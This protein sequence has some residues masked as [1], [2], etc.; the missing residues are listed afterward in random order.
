[1]R[2]RARVDRL[3]GT[4][5]CASRP[6]A[7]GRTAIGEFAETAISGAGE[8]LRDVVDARELVGRDLQVHLEAR[9]ARLDHHRVVL[10][11]SSS[12]RPLIE[13]SNLP[14]RSAVTI[15]L[16]VHVARARHHVVE[17]EVA[18]CASSAGCP[19]ARRCMPS[20]RG[21]AARACSTSSSSCVSICDEA[22]AGEQLRIAVD[23]ELELAELGRVVRVARRRS[24]TCSDAARRAPALV[25]RGTSPARRRC[26]ARR[27]RTC[28]SA[29][30]RSSARRSAR[31]ARHE[32][33]LR[34]RRRARPS[35]SLCVR[36]VGHA[37]LAVVHSPRILRQ[38]LAPRQP[39]VVPLGPHESTRFGMPCRP[40]TF[41]IA[42]DSPMSS[43]LALAR[44][45]A[46]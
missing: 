19:S 16:S 1:M 33:A 42:H 18:S 40:S 38:H 26:G 5:R 30:M 23:L 2:W 28:S 29:S 46:G 37:S 43:A 39:V 17:A 24:S 45:R 32:L 4:A 25:D 13:T 3:L 41:A 44:R 8:H 20:S 27:S 10:E 12:S 36:V 14:P 6:T 21:R 34:A 22:V 11:R 9:V 31:I 7:A 15:L 35:T